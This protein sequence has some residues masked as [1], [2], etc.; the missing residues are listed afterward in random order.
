MR[1]IGFFFGFFFSFLLPVS[2]LCLHFFFPMHGWSGFVY[3]LFLHYF[4]DGVRW[5]GMVNEG[6]VL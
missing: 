4:R 1:L 6:T 5:N 2:L 3:Y